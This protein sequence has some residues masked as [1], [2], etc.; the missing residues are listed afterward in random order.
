MNAS[1]KSMIGELT[2]STN[3]AQGMAL[4]PVIWSTGATL[5]SITSYPALG[6]DVD[7]I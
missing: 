3:I 6:C 2:D 5:G 1:F 4:M 7:I